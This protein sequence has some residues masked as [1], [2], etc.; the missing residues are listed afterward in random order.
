MVPSFRSVKEVRIHR[1]MEKS[2]F[3]RRTEYDTC[4]CYQKIYGYKNSLR[5]SR[6]TWEWSGPRNGPY[7][8][9]I[10]QKCK[11]SVHIWSTMRGFRTI[12]HVWCYTES[13]S[14]CF[15]FCQPTNFKV[16]LF[17]FFSISYSRRKLFMFYVYVLEPS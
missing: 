5:K 11:I 3:K 6:I 2:Y 9:K 16:N 10:W 13:W 4:I 7:R 15:D 1:I 14:R 12:F 8:S 17:N